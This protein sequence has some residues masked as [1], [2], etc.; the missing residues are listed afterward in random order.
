MRRVKKV[1]MILLIVLV[2][3]GIGVSVFVNQPS[4]GRSPRGNRLTRI[5]KSPNYKNDHFENELPTRVITGQKSGLRTMWEFL[6][7]KRTNLRPQTSIPSVKTDLNNLP[8]DKDYIVWFGHSAYLLQLSG[9]RI[10]VD[11]TLLSASPVSFFNK[12]YAGTELYKPADL[13]E[14]DF[15]VI[16]HDHWDHLDYKTVT[17]LKDRIKHII[18]PLGVGEHFVYWEFSENKLTELDWYE[19]A[20]QDDFVFDCLPARHFSGRGLIG[21]KT[22]WGSFVVRTPDHKTIYI[23]GDS[24]Y[25]THFKWIGEHYPNLTLAILENGQYNENWNQIHTMPED[26][27][28]EMREL[29]AKNYITVHHSKYTLS[30]HTWDSPLKVEQQAA[31]EAKVNLT[32]LTIGQPYEIK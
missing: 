30:K 32:V 17:E 10:L 19:S 6:T 1:S 29:G 7:E 20:K 9:K 31:K 26:L 14:V 25:S 16:S 23:G 5:R 13:P 24:G 4:F 3:L 18:T 11:P 21:N 27:P 2:I 8:K 15:L 28:R 22:L 12:P